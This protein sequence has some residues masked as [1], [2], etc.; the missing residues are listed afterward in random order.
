MAGFK[1]ELSDVSRFIISLIEEDRSLSQRG[2]A[3]DY[4]IMDVCLT[5][6]R[7]VHT[8]M[9]S[10]LSPAHARGIKLSKTDVPT[11]NE[12]ILNSECLLSHASSIPSSHD[13]SH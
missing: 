9:T 4:A 12:T 2:T 8:P 6:E 11:L 1:A 13:N 7:L 5:L 3:L 10:P